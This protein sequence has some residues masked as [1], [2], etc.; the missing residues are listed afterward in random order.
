MILSR[1]VHCSQQLT[2]TVLVGYLHDE[3]IMDESNIIL[4]VKWQPSIDHHVTRIRPSKCIGKEHQAH[5]VHFHHPVKFITYFICSLINCMGSQV[6]VGG[7]HNISSRDTKLT[8]MWWLWYK[9]LLIKEFPPPFL[10]Y[11]FL[12]TQKVPTMSNELTY[13]LSAFIKLFR[14]I[15]F[16]S[17]RS[18]LLKWLDQYPPSWYGWSLIWNVWVV[19]YDVIIH[20][21]D[22]Q[23][24]FGMSE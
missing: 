10:A 9:Y 19:L 7:P 2:D 3:I 5:H 13:S 4:F 16:P 18:L 14:H 6:V 11:T 17:V 24:I 21:S 1:P 20:P 15:L 23:V 12:L 8:K 22:N